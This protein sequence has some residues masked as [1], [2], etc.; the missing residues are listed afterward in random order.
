MIH[1]IGSIAAGVAFA[2]AAL[3][4]VLYHLTA[5]WRRSEEGWHLMT[6]TALHA[7]VFGWIGYRIIVASARDLPPAED[8]ARA[9]IYAIAA[10]CLVWRLLL[11]WSRQIGPGLRRKSKP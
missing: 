5:P 1:T 6:F 3:F 4:C 10:A 11:L 8:A 7:A 9:A 2:A